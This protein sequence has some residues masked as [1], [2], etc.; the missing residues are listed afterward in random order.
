MSVREAIIE[1]VMAAGYDMFIACEQADEII[2]EFK[3][4]GEKRKTWGITGAH[5]KCVDTVTIARK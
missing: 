3:A 2:A 5:G 4:S 1:K